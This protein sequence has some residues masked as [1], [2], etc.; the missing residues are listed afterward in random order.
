MSKVNFDTV[1]ECVST[2]YG[3]LTGIIQ[4]DRHSNITSICDLCEDHKFDTKDKLIIGF[5]FG[6]STILGIGKDDSY[7]AEN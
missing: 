1:K 7:R 4:R 5:G 6:E 3:D 2:Q